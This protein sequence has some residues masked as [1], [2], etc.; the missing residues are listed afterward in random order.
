MPR[1]RSPDQASPRSPV[2]G[3]MARPR[4]AQGEHLTMGTLRAYLTIDL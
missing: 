3:P 2:S 1:G 4:E